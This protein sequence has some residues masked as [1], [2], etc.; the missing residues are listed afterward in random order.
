MRDDVVG[1]LKERPKLQ[2]RST[3]SERVITKIKEFVETFI[4][5]VD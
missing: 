1:M 2:E 5:G 3:I 4:D